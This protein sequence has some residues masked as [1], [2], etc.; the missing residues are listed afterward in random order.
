M[1]MNLPE[2]K[3]CKD[4]YHLQ[5]CKGIYGRIGM[6]EIC[7]WHPSKFVELINKRKL[8]SLPEKN[9]NMSLQ[10]IKSKGWSHSDRP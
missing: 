4:C 10:Y 9:L 2:G 1:E 5:R 3:Y 7:D 6:D 8:E